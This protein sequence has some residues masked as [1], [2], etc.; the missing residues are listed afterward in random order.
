MKAFDDLFRAELIRQS[1]SND[2][3]LREVQRSYGSPP[4]TLSAALDM[5]EAIMK[6]MKRITTIQGEPFKN[7]DIDP[8]I[9]NAVVN[10]LLQYQPESEWIELAEAL[11]GPAH[12]AKMLI[13]H[14]E[15]RRSTSTRPYKLSAEQL[16][17]IGLFVSRLEKTF[18]ER[19]DM[20]QPWNHPA[21]VIMTVIMD[22]GGGCGK[23]I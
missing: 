17:C 1:P 3:K 2:A 5:Q 8:I 18:P 6:H 9:T 7:E 15:K 14:C 12:V 20:S 13:Q 10:N 4:T 16:E 21:R 19:A 11:K 23:T 22:G